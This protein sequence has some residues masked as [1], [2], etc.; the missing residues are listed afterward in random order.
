[1]LFILSFLIS[2]ISSAGTNSS[3]ETL[4]EINP[5]ITLLGQPD[6]SVTYVSEKGLLINMAVENYRRA[7]N[8]SQEDGWAGGITIG[9]AS[10]GPFSV[11]LQGGLRFN[12]GKVD[13]K[14][15]RS[16]RTQVAFNEDNRFDRWRSETK[17]L[18][19]QAVTGIRWAEGVLSFACQLRIIDD[20]QMVETLRSRDF[21]D[22]S[23]PIPEAGLLRQKTVRLLIGLRL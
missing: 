1:M 18:S 14:K 23:E 6:A 7:R 8:F 19:A 10:K 13:W 9:V 5:L 20:L 17:Y 15:L 4:L 3:A 21:Y 2:G 22:A 12:Q 11:M 16:V